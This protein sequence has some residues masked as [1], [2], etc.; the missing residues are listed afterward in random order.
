MY[1][2]VIE[3]TVIMKFAERIGNPSDITKEDSISDTNPYL[4]CIERHQSDESYSSMHF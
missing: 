2:S 1:N 3:R 4:I